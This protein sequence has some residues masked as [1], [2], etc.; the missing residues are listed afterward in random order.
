METWTG[1]ETE[2]REAFLR[3]DHRIH[4]AR[5]RREFF[6]HEPDEDARVVWHRARVLDTA[7]HAPDH[8]DDQSPRHHG[9]SREWQVGKFAW[10]D[11]YCSNICG[12]HRP[13]S[14]MVQVA[15]RSFLTEQ[16][17]SRSHRKSLHR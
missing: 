5:R 2:R 15:A 7:S 12:D 9:S 4:A 8:A 3:F 11:Y 14:Y 17:A 1:C 16:P 10:M 13:R 6:R